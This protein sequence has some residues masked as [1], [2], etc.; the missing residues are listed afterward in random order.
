MISEYWQI[1]ESGHPVDSSHIWALYNLPP[2][3]RFWQEWRRRQGYLSFFLPH[4]C[5]PPAGCLLKKCAGM[6]HCRW[7]QIFLKKSQASEFT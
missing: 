7:P 3:Q 5:P 1:R 2:V 4:L 6:G